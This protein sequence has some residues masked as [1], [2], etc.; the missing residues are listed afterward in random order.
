VGHPRTYSPR[1]PTGNTAVCTRARCAPDGPA[2][3]DTGSPAMSLSATEDRGCLLDAS[4]DGFATTW[5]QAGGH[6]VVTVASDSTVPGSCC[7]R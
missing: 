6:W 7:G 2:F 3:E 5:N 1:S 4:F